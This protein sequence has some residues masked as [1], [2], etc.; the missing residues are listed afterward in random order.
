[1]ETLYGKKII[2]CVNTKHQAHNLLQTLKETY[3]GITLMY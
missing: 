3:K 1:M 2:L